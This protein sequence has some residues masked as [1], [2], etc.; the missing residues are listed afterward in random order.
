MLPLNR[1]VLDSEI[2]SELF[3]ETADITTTSV[4]VDPAERVWHQYFSERCLLPHSADL[5]I[6]CERIPG[7]ESSY[8]LHFFSKIAVKEHDINILFS[9]FKHHHSVRIYRKGIPIPSRTSE[10]SGQ[11][12]PE[13]PP[14]DAWTVSAWTLSGATSFDGFFNL[15]L[16]EF[17]KD[18]R[19]ILNHFS[20][21]EPFQRPSAI[22][23]IAEEL[24]A[25]LVKPAQESVDSWAE[26]LAEELSM[27][28]D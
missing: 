2:S 3:P 9:R 6:T 22:M 7:K 1:I 15:E 16:V 17:E 28:T 8:P 13:G 20:R 27:T 12:Y 21:P 23:Q 14:D 5:N 19:N 4:A 24:A 26:R 25:N 18:M 11:F 10:P